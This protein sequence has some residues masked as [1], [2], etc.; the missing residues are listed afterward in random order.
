MKHFGSRAVASMDAPPEKRLCVAWPGGDLLSYRATLEELFR[1]GPGEVLKLYATEAGSLEH[2]RLCTDVGVENLEHRLLFRTW[3][4]NLSSV[5]E[6]QDALTGA[7]PPWAYAVDVELDGSSG[8][9]LGLDVNHADG[10]T[11]LVKSVAAGGLVAEWNAG[12]LASAQIGPG[13]RIMAVNGCSGDASKL[14]AEC[15]RPQVLRLRVQRPPEARFRGAT[16]QYYDCGDKLELAAEAADHVLP[17]PEAFPYIP[18]ATELRVNPPLEAD[19][20]TTR[21]GARFF[22]NFGGRGGGCLCGTPACEE[23]DA[24]AARQASTGA[25]SFAVSLS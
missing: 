7:L 9:S 22:I 25:S 1:N 15:R 14:L 20:Y 5:G 17:P 21:P 23:V 8:G 2:E 11:L 10:R 18:A 6:D 24:L 16:V 12:S 4:E 3:F 19:E 13:D